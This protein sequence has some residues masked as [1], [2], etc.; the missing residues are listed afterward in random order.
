MDLGLRGKVAIVTG[1]SDGIG[2]ATARSL[3]ARGR[4]SCPVCQARNAA[5][6]GA[7]CHRPKRLALRSS[8]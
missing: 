4:A 2:F 1:S 3:G 6:A 5:N 8:R 7:R